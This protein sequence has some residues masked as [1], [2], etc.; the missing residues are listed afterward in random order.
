LATTR[1]FDDLAR[2][3]TDLD[4]LVNSPCVSQLAFNPLRMVH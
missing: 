3:A 1:S 4:A 2:R